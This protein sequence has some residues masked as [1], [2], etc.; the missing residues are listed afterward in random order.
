MVELYALADS[1]REALVIAVQCAECHETFVPTIGNA[2]I[3]EPCVERL[4]RIYEA[5]LEREAYLA[6][7]FKMMEAAQ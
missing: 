3:C 5:T 6:G 4:E 2:D 1:G 7:E